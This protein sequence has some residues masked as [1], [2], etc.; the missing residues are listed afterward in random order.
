MGLT[1]YI[2]KKKVKK[3]AGKVIDGEAAIDKTVDN[4]L[5]SIKWG[6]LIGMLARKT[7]GWL[8]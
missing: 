8:K 4:F 3:L 5:S 6:E 2:F 1:N 7:I